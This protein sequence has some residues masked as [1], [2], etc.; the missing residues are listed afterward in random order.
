MP[1]IQISSESIAVRG[2]VFN[3]TGVIR[4]ENIGVTGET[5]TVAFDNQLLGTVET[6][7]NGSYTW[8]FLVDSEENLG[9]H[10]L[11]VALQ[12]ESDLFAVQNVMVKSKT[13]LTTKI[14]DAAGGMFLL[15][16]ASLSDDHNLPVPNAEIVVDGYGLAWK[17]DRNGNLT[18]LLDNV[19]L[20]SENFVITA[21]FEGSERYSSAI[22][23]KEV[24]TEPVTSLPFLIPLGFPILAVTLF[25]YFKHYSG[26]QQAVQQ[27]GDTSAAEEAIVEEEFVHRPQEMQPLKIVLPDIEAPFPNVWGVEDELRIEIVLDKSASEGDQK[28]D[29][30]VFID[31]ETAGPFRLSR[32]GRAELSRRFTKKGGHKV[33]AILFGT[34]GQVHLSAEIELRIVDYEE[35][36]V[37][38]YNEFLEKLPSHGFDVRNEMT[39]Q[40]IASLISKT[41]NFSPEALRRV[42]TCFEKAEYSNHL[43]TREDYAIM[44]LSL[45]ELNSD[46]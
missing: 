19:K 16:S 20:W 26:R 36:I 33:R 30:K 25:V 2:E 23:E 10:Y 45:R 44:F 42:T 9:L 6:G 22:T 38:L 39:A 34:S 17:T 40:E 1:T 8:S 3:I 24:A 35:E 13:T 27:T 31:E 5:V 12:K 11:N 14:S 4:F 15:L 18:F 32:K 43:T 21:R 28:R 41:R 46:I 37:R 7:N 29:V